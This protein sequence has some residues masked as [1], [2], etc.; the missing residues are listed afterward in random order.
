MAYLE[1]VQQLKLTV[2]LLHERG[3]D[4][5]RDAISTTAL[6]GAR[7][8]ERA[9]RKGGLDRRM[10]SALGEIESGAF[11]RRFLRAC[12]RA[13][14]RLNMSRPASDREREMA[15]IG[16]AVRSLFLRGR[17][18]ARSRRRSPKFP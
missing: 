12:G 14:P 1:C 18:P 15:E 11:G 17:P 10:R 5:L 13:D 7:G 4:G 8:M 2:D 6:F 9:L 3:P 16:R